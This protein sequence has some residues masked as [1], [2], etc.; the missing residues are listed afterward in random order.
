MS[1]FQEYSENI[2]QGRLC[3]RGERSIY[4]SA[5]IVN[6]SFEL[7]LL[8]P[9]PFPWAHRSGTPTYR[10]A[11]TQRND[12]WQHFGFGAGR[13]VAYEL[14]PRE[15]IHA[16]RDVQHIFLTPCDQGPTLL[17]ADR[18]LRDV[19]K[20]SSKTL[21]VFEHADCDNTRIRP[22]RIVVGHLASVRGAG[23]CRS[24]MMS[25]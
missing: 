13:C 8:F 9:S 24:M 20:P 12:T 21:I 5:S 6:M 14:R 18:A 25:P 10:T 15:T 4:T 7:D 16:N 1:I 3:P 23:R 2:P 17:E 11:G 22:L 19:W